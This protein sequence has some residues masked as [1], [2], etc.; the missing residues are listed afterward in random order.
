MYIF[1]SLSKDYFMGI[2]DYFTKTLGV[3]PGS[4]Y[5]RICSEGKIIYNDFTA[6][7]LATDGKVTGIGKNAV[8]NKS[9]FWLR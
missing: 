9:A 8:E 5:L 7:S 2:F 1:E 6:L 4:A 3:D